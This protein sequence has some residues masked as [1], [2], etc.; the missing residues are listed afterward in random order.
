MAPDLDIDIEGQAGGF[1]LAVRLFVERG[2]VALVGP[3]GAGKTTLLRVLAGGL[4]Q[5]KGR[6][7]VRGRT[8]MDTATGTWLPPE[9][10]RI[11]YLPQSYGLFAHLSAVDNVGYGIRG[12]KGR[13]R[14]D[15]AQALLAE[16]GVAHLSHQHPW[17]LSGGE[18]QRVALA[19]ALATSP[20]LLLLDEPTAAID[21][22]VRPQMR[23]VLNRQFR[24][25][26][27]CAVVVTHDLRDL[28]AWSPTIVLLEQGRVV[29]QGSISELRARSRHPFL[30]ELLSPFQSG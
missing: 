1:S 18:Q 29:E 19:R 8:L 5:A 22:A 28:M 10:R 27:L 12:L 9:A 24:Q 15:R 30:M 13:A 23:Y 26:S 17:K 6:V 21:V 14:K 16:F 4:T 7:L 11:G 20:E 25:P 3:N 2:P